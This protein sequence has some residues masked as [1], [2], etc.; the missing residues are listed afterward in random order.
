[1]KQCKHCGQIYPLEEF[2]LGR[3]GRGY[4]FRKGNCHRCEADRMRSWRQSRRMCP[5]C[6]KYRP[7]GWFPVSGRGVRC[8]ECR[9]APSHLHSQEEYDSR[10]AN[11]MADYEYARDILGWRENEII[12]WIAEGYGVEVRTVE[13][14]FQEK[15]VDAA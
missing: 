7:R 15:K 6:K 4:S 9:K 5:G 2:W 14:W 3:N 11:A 12:R 10:K 13:R 1:M 8:D